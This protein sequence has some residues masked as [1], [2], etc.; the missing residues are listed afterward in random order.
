[1]TLIN[2][3]LIGLIIL[4]GIVLWALISMSGIWRIFEY[5]GKDLKDELEKEKE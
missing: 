1:M 5:I 4:G 3:V 2:P